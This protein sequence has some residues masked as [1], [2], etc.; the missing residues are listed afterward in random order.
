MRILPQLDCAAD[1]I[2]VP[3]K[4]PMLLLAGANITSTLE[5][6]KQGDS[7]KLPVLCSALSWQMLWKW[8]RRKGMV[9]M[10]FCVPPSQMPLCN[11]HVSRVH[12]LPRRTFLLAALLSLLTEHSVLGI[13]LI[14]LKG[15]LLWPADPPIWPRVIFLGGYLRSIVYNDWPH[16]KNN[17]YAKPSPMP[18]HYQ[19]TRQY[20]SASWTELQKPTFWMHWEWGPS[21][22]LWHH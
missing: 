13:S 22:V 7:Q 3:W 18:S 2:V 19:H 21:F 12:L 17:I 15:N 14:S 4:M 9:V 1:S 6:F 16:L 10:K 8:A 20:V 11:G 5:R